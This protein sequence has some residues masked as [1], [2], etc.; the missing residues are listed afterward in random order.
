MKLP[1]LFSALLCAAITAS[2]QDS[3]G[4]IRATTKLRPDGTTSTTITDPEKRTAEETISDANRKVLRK[5]TYILGERDISIGAIFAD[6]KGKVIYKASYVRDGAGRVIE[7]AFTSPED[8]YLGKR[9]FV[10]GA[11]DAVARVEDYD[12]QGRLIA[13]PA[14]ATKPTTR[15][16]R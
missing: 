7:T 16:R 2:A 11:G 13:R 15:K 10:Y 9:I 1:A 4:T 6:A 8:K 5:T 12:A 14:A 3:Y